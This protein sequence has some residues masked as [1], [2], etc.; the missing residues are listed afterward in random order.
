MMKNKDGY[1]LI[2][3]INQQREADGWRNLYE[4][5]I[6]AKIDKVV[7][8]KTN[9]KLILYKNDVVLY[10]VM[11]SKKFQQFFYLDNFFSDDFEWNIILNGV[12]NS[13]WICI[14]PFDYKRP[15]LKEAPNLINVYSS[16]SKKELLKHVRFEDTYLSDQI[17]K[18]K[19]K[20]IEVPP[21]QSHFII[22]QSNKSIIARIENDKIQK[23]GY[24]DA[25]YNSKSV[26]TANNQIVSLCFTQKA[27]RIF[28]LD[29]KLI[30]EILNIYHKSIACKK[31]TIFLGGEVTDTRYELCGEMCSTINLESSNITLKEIEIPVKIVKGKSIDDILIEG[32]NLVLVDNVITPKY[33]FEYDISDPNNPDLKA[34]RVHVSNGTYEHIYKGDINKSWT[35]LLSSTTSSLSG[36]THITVRGRTDGILSF[37]Y[38][39]KSTK[40]THDSIRD[41]C[42][43]NNL[44]YILRNSGLH[45]INL[46]NSI[47]KFKIK[48]IKDCLIDQPNRLIKTPCDKLIV[49]NE[50]NYALIKQPVLKPN[51][52]KEIWEWLKSN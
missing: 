29:G 6:D 21:I 17:E 2:N 46:D 30:N 52:L 48:K 44:L 45:Y 13:N 49:L 28:N 42:L 27:L 20:F 38:S 39:H 22:P 11:V 18:S 47:S 16:S 50:Q 37:R 23:V 32:N 12:Q 35:I 7:V 15:G 3:N 1:D 9:K 19:E 36:G 31:N 26:I 24:I 33:L 10:N 40:K 41:I 43:I 5:I 25:P 51:L 14:H 34:T 4:F 8:D